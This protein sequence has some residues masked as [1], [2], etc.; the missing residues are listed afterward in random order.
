MKVS[1][2]DQGAGISPDDL[3]KIFDPYF[4]TKP[5]G[6]GLGLAT[7]RSIVK[8]HGGY[9]AVETALGRG[10]TIDI[11]L[12]ASPAARRDE[13]PG[14]QRVR[15]SGNGRLLV[16]D[17]EPSIRTLTIRLLGMLGYEAT[18]V[19]KGSEAIE[20]YQRARDEGHPFDL[21]LLDLT[22]PGEL[23]GSDVLRVLK[24]IDRGVKAIVVSGYA[25]DDVLANYRDY[26]FKAVVTKPFTMDELSSALLDV[27]NAPA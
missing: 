13:Q 17:D 23:G 10:T 16:L 26:G 11:C 9:I 25:G 15:R 1:I 24:T 20:Q 4:S 5:T 2:A 3:P 12:P 6:T 8:N 18:A 19:A 22:I 21:V 7:S 14:A 27:V